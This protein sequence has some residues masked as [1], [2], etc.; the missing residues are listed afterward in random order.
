MQGWRLRMEDAHIALPQLKD[1]GAWSDIAVFSVLDGHGGEHVARF[2]Q[3][4]L[5]V[6]IARRPSEDIPGALSGA[7]HR[8]D[9]L[10]ADPGCVPELLSLSDDSSAGITKVIHPDFIGTTCV[11]CCI[12]RDVYVVANAGDSRAVLCRQG[13]AIDLSED[14][15][16]YLPGEHAR[17]ERAGGFVLERDVGRQKPLYRV[18]GDLSISR[19]IGDLR[20]KK[21]THLAPKDQ[22]VC[23]T[24]DIQTVRRDQDD[25]FLVLACDGI[26][27]V[28]S[29]QEVVDYIRPKLAGVLDGSVKLS[30]VI[31]GLL[32]YCLSPDPARTFG[33]GGDNM[34][35]VVVV[36]TGSAGLGLGAAGHAAAEPPSLAGGMLGALAARCM[37]DLPKAGVDFPRGFCTGSEFPRG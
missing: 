31:E 17:I 32:D 2:C 15:K 29:S 21:N 34:T 20:F 14:H 13:K 28:L 16:P 35:V 37:V 8:M 11:V 3:R 30:S 4:H 24:P 5:P 33:L 36:F 1:G 26:W 23:C 7:F 9:E 12:R 10:L 19:A 18:N 22:V 25:E 6:E 27:D